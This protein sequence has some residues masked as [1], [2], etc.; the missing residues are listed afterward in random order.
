MTL[1]DET[2]IITG[3]SE[4]KEYLGRIIAGETNATVAS[5]REISP[6]WYRENI[7]PFA[8]AAKEIPFFW[9]WLPNTYSD[10]VGFAW[11]IEDIKAVNQRPIGVMQFDIVM[12]GIACDA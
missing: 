1:N 7:R 2:D 10:E 6:N 9:A 4:N 8:K 3:V 11:T 5:F 12:R